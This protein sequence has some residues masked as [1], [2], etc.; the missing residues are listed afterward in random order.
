MMAAHVRQVAQ[1]GWQQPGEL[2]AWLD[3]SGLVD[4]R[5]PGKEDRSRT[6]GSALVLYRGTDQR[7]KSSE[8]R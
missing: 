7:S 2:R 5:T 8:N 4:R 3:S 6:G 1:Q